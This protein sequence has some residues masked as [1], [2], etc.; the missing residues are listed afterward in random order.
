MYKQLGWELPE[1]GTTKKAVTKKRK[2]DDA[3][4][5]ETPKKKPRAKKG[6]GG[7]KKAS[8][9][10][11]AQLG[12][13]K[14]QDGGED[15]VDVED[16]GESKQDSSNGEG[17]DV[18]EPEKPVKKPRAKKAV[19]KKPTV[20]EDLGSEGEAA[21]ETEAVVKEEKVKKPTAEKVVA[22]KSSPKPVEV[23]EEIVEENI[24]DE[25]VG[26]A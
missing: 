12:G 21:G 17:A 24:E 20:V 16:A 10:E 3:G 1:G 9:D 7:E 11:E 2:D 26:E 5:G 6:A 18:K 13:I 22:K 23:K 8:D 15:S 14:K 19:A 25:D 4:E